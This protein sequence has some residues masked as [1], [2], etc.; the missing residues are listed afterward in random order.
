MPNH[1]ADSHRLWPILIVFLTGAPVGLLASGVCERPPDPSVAYPMYNRLLNIRLPLRQDPETR[2]WAAAALRSGPDGLTTAGLY[3]LRHLLATVFPGKLWVHDASSAWLEANGTQLGMRDLIVELNSPA[4]SDHCSHVFQQHLFMAAETRAADTHF[5]FR[6][7]S[8]IRVEY[9]YL[10]GAC[11]PSKEETV[12]FFGALRLDKSESACRN[13]ASAQDAAATAA[14]GLPADLHR[15][16]DR[17]FFMP[18]SRFNST[19]PASNATSSGLIF[20]GGAPLPIILQSNSRLLA[21]II[22]FR[23]RVDNPTTDW[24]MLDSDIAQ[25][26]AQLSRHSDDYGVQRQGAA[27]SCLN[28]LNFAS[29]PATQLAASCVA[30]YDISA[31]VSVN[32]SL[33]ESADIR[34]PQCETIAS[35]RADNSR[36]VIE[37]RD[38][39]ASLARSNSTAHLFVPA[40]HSSAYVHIRSV[41][42]SAQ[43]KRL[44]VDLSIKLKAR[45]PALLRYPLVLQSGL[46]RNINAYLVRKHLGLASVRL[47]QPVSAYSSDCGNGGNGKPAPDNDLTLLTRLCA[48]AKLAGSVSI[49]R[50]Q[51][52]LSL[53]RQSLLAQ[54]PISRP[55][56]TTGLIRFFLIAAVSQIDKPEY[57]SLTSNLSLSVSHQ[58][59]GKT[60]NAAVAVIDVK[61]S[62]AVNDSFKSSDAADFNARFVRS[63][64]LISGDFGP[65]TTLNS[66]ANVERRSCNAAATATPGPATTPSPTPTPKKPDGSTADLDANHA[67]R[68]VFTVSSKLLYGGRIGDYLLTSGLNAALRR[69]GLRDIEDVDLT[70]KDCRAGDTCRIT[71]MILCSNHSSS[72]SNATSPGMHDITLTALTASLS[73]DSLLQPVDL[74]ADI[75]PTLPPQQIPASSII[76]RYATSTYFSRPPPVMGS[77]SI[78]PVRLTILWRLVSVNAS[79]PLAYRSWPT[80][81]QS[82]GANRLQ[83]LLEQMLVDLLGGRLVSWPVA[84]RYKSDSKL[85]RLDALVA[86]DAK[87]PLARL[88]DEASATADKMPLFSFVR[89]SDLRLSGQPTASGLF[90]SALMLQTYL[91]RNFVSN[92]TLQAMPESDL[93]RL[94]SG[95][96][97]FVQSV[98]FSGQQGRPQLVSFEYRARRQLDASI[99]IDGLSR[100]AWPANRTAVSATG[101]NFDETSLSKLINSELEALQANVNVFPLV[102]DNQSSTLRLLDTRTGLTAPR[103]CD[104]LLRFR[105]S[106]AD[107]AVAAADASW[108]PV[109]NRLSAWLGANASHVTVLSLPTDPSGTIEALAVVPQAGAAVSCSQ[110]AVQLLNWSATATSDKRL[111]AARSLSDNVLSTSDGPSTANLTVLVRH[112]ALQPFSRQSSDSSGEYFCFLITWAHALFNTNSEGGVCVSNLVE[113]HR[114]RLNPLSNATSAALQLSTVSAFTSMPPDTVMQRFWAFKNFY[115]SSN[116]SFIDLDRMRLQQ[117]DQQRPNS[118]EDSYASLIIR[119]LPPA[120]EHRVVNVSTVAMETTTAATVVQTSVATSEATTATTTTAAATD[121]A[122]ATPAPGGPLPTTQQTLKGATAAAT[123]TPAPTSPHPMGPDYIPIDRMATLSINL[124]MPADPWLARYFLAAAAPQSANQTS[125]EE[126]KALSDYLLKSALQQSLQRSAWQIA[127]DEIGA[128]RISVDSNSMTIY[129]S[130]DLL[131]PASRNIADLESVLRTGVDQSMLLSTVFSKRAYSVLIVNLPT[132]RYLYRPQPAVATPQPPPASARL[133]IDQTMLIRLADTA[134]D[135]LRLRTVGGMDSSAREDLL[136]DFLFQ[137][138]VADAC[139]SQQL[140]GRPRLIRYKADKE[141]AL[142]QLRYDISQVNASRLKLFSSDFASAWQRRQPSASTLRSILYLDFRPGPPPPHRGLLLYQR[143]RLESYINKKSLMS[144]PSD[145]LALL[146]RPKIRYVMQ[147][148]FPGGSASVP[149]FLDVDATYA[150]KDGAL[151]IVALTRVAIPPGFRLAKLEQRLQLHVMQRLEQLANDINLVPSV[152]SVGKTDVRVVDLKEGLSQPFWCDLVYSF[153]V[154]SARLPAQGFELATYLSQ[155]LA[156]KLQQPTHLERL[157]VL[158]WGPATGSSATHLLEVQALVTMSSSRSLPFDQA[159]SILMKAAAAVESPSRLTTRAVAAPFHGSSSAA[160]LGPGSSTRYRRVNQAVTFISGNSAA[161]ADSDKLAKYACHLYQSSLESA[162]WFA[163]YVVPHSCSAAVTAANIRVAVSQQQ[164]QLS[165]PGLRMNISA[166]VVSQTKSVEVASTATRAFQSALAIK[167]FY[168]NSGELVLSEGVHVQDVSVYIS[169]QPDSVTKPAQLVTN[170]TTTGTSAAAATTTDST[171]TTA[172]TA[173]TVATTTSPASASTIATTTRPRTVLYYNL[174]LQFPL[175]NATWD[176]LAEPDSPMALLLA[177]SLLNDALLANASVSKLAQ[178]LIVTNI[179]RDLSDNATTAELGLG[180]ALAKFQPPSAVDSPDHLRLSVAQ[181]VSNWPL[182]AALFTDRPIV[183]VW[184]EFEPLPTPPQNSTESDTPAQPSA[185]KSRRRRSTSSAASSEFVEHRLQLFASPSL[186]VFY[187]YRDIPLR[188]DPLL[189]FLTQ[190]L[191]N[192]AMQRWTNQT[193]SDWPKLAWLRSDNISV[194]LC[195]R[196]PKPAGLSQRQ[197]MD[198]FSAAWV[199]VNN[200]LAS[201]SLCLARHQELRPVATADAANETVGLLIYQRLQFDGFVGSDTMRKLSHDDLNQL[202]RHRLHFIL[203]Q[204][205]PGNGTSLGNVSSLTLAGFDFECYG[206]NSTVIAFLLVR[207]LARADVSEADIR[208][209]VTKQLLRLATNEHVLPAQL[210]SRGIDLRLLTRRTGLPAGVADWFD[211]QATFDYAEEGPS[212]HGYALAAGARRHLE[213]LLSRSSASSNSIRVVQLRLMRWKRLGSGG[214]GRHHQLVSVLATLASTGPRNPDSTPRQLR[215]QLANLTGL[216]SS[217]LTLPL[218]DF[219]HQPQHYDRH[220]LQLMHSGVAVQQSVHLVDSGPA[221]PDSRNDSSLTSDFICLLIASAFRQRG[222]GRLRFVDDLCAARVTQ[223][224]LLR[225]H[226]LSARR[227]PATAAAAY[228]TLHNSS[229]PF[230]PDEATDAINQLASSLNAYADIAGRSLALGEVTPIQP[231]PIYQLLRFDSAGFPDDLRNS[232][233]L[234][235]LDTTEAIKRSLAVYLRGVANLFSGQVTA[236]RYSP[237][238]ILVSVSYQIYPRLLDTGSA[239]KHIE[240]NTEALFSSS[241]PFHGLQLDRDGSF[242]STAPIAVHRQPKLDKTD[243]QSVPIAIYCILGVACLLLLILSTLLIIRLYRMRRNN[244][245]SRIRPQQPSTNSQRRSLMF[246]SDDKPQQQQQRDAEKGLTATATSAPAPAPAPAS[247]NPA[248]SRPDA[249]ESSNRRNSNINNTGRAADPTRLPSTEVPAPPRLPQPP[250]SRRASAAASSRRASAASCSRTAGTAPNAGSNL[251]PNAAPNVAPSSSPNAHPASQV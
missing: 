151:E 162:H 154:E 135:Y 117:L 232:S 12:H 33:S 49:L 242:V 124:S 93:H 176:Y 196:Y 46:Q 133:S 243:E 215:A 10:F 127:S 144:L 48:T 138:L 118:S 89:L 105:P 120:P 167:N 223:R 184:P 70:A 86:L 199:A 82:S 123:T 98:I 102:F 221:Q 100:I 201:C 9:H 122:K 121:E 183:T 53:D 233:S 108:L 188:P 58:V 143:L 22:D 205:Y 40:N 4:D 7:F 193:S 139:G 239:A 41:S 38:I 97:R 134:P 103:W 125:A 181:A 194:T 164:P 152:F 61:V 179:S 142:L 128:V 104:L 156:P 150:K 11:Q 81:P 77:T 5:N 148:V 60:S 96:L 111:I 217:N 240:L 226:P 16:T 163:L 251:A 208:D 177:R 88:S 191:L 30:C 175:S 159:T 174:K 119:Q 231:V 147:Q 216:T 31:S 28:Y 249:P 8:D 76:Y 6:Q 190:R 99:R 84:V 210:S 37:T 59:A 126:A 237:G 250:E 94:L 155:L 3:E 157:A 63:I 203:G 17:L 192:T 169:V 130:V 146:L 35:V 153:T 69:A 64:R 1:L 19:A 247:E 14:A 44:V 74:R 56:L 172:T 51:F 158:Q 238:S 206:R 112:S 47:S 245:G 195:I 222:S 110:V 165:I 106:P 185:S 15:L 80:N 246:D 21:F 230:N 212:L 197:V 34:P 2:S 182:A 241:S 115:L 229:Q 91:L 92:A 65:L 36:R 170:S 228:F 57:R 109:A 178:H 218:Q 136:L 140:I 85:A 189:S 141:L 166:T 20:S 71:A 202:M 234:L 207:L 73:G 13:L 186:P 132:R 79:A 220:H 129:I 83:F 149:Q 90:N 43:P 219:D 116:E 107:I 50:Q 101:A 236:V 24:L 131:L 200:E 173:I 214:P 209:H 227:I 42:C 213:A 87:S 244:Y 211:V 168:F 55:D 26:Y 225:P 32:I 66:A 72:S 23:L 68:L 224:G 52:Q 235:Y 27:P 171:D 18:S 75:V 62:Y 248:A 161:L 204:L 180:Q 29:P 113:Q 67:L 187:R 78:A 39:L 145:Y 45:H 25:R 95:K 54:V 198:G 160:S 137:Q 114:I